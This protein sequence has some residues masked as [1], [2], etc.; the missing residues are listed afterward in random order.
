[1]FTLL[2]IA[3]WLL[4]SYSYYSSK[5][6]TEPRST[7][8]TPSITNFLPP[9]TTTSITLPP[10]PD[11]T[12]LPT[13]TNNEPEKIEISDSDLEVIVQ[14]LVKMEIAATEVVNLEPKQP[15]IQAPKKPP[16]KAH[17]KPNN[18]QTSKRK[19]N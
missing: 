14:P 7:V 16:V 19:K 3:Q 17:A 11:E 2:V 13:T 9:D 12:T 18:L 15:T 10:L 1:M 4:V 5:L 8:E 6:L